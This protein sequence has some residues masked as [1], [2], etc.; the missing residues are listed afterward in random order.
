MPLKLYRLFIFYLFEEYGGKYFISYFFRIYDI[1]TKKL[2]F[3]YYSQ[4]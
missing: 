1:H 3:Y 4:K 2:T